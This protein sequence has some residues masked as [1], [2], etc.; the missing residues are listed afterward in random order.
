MIKKNKGFV[1]IHILFLISCWLLSGC[2]TESERTT[3]KSESVPKIKIG[4]LIYNEDDTFVSTIVSYFEETSKL[5]EQTNN[6]KIT[7]N[8]VDAK[9]SQTTQNDQLDR[10]IEQ[11]YDVICINIVDRTAAATMIDRAKSADIPVIF[12]NREPV[13]EDLERWDKVYYVGAIAS[14]SGMLQGH[15]VIDAYNKDTD[16]IDKN[17]DGKLQYV[18]LEGEQGHQDALVRTEYVIK[19][20]TAADIKMEKL[21]NDTANWQRAP[22]STKITQWLEKYGDNIE[23]VLCNND[24]MALGAVDAYIAKGIKEMPVIVGIDCTPPAIEAIK[25]GQMVGTVLNDAKGQAEAMLDLSYAL[26]TEKGVSS[27]RY[28][29]YVRMPYHSV[30][31]EN[32]EVVE[33]EKM[34]K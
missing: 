10:M 1:M 17:K 24:D 4:V 7:I 3:D 13:E 28:N 30:T 33:A 14:E 25:N 16:K 9:G 19:T 8:V 27:N 26:A 23:V 34:L 18:M 22:A 21:A 5:K 32:V 15:I 6:I 11:G 20:I 29:K 31:I 2:S 12:F